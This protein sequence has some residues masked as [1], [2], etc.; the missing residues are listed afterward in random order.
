MKK[1]FLMTAIAVAF[2]NPAIAHD[3]KIKGKT[4]QTKESKIVATEFMKAVKSLR[5]QGIKTGTFNVTMDARGV[6]LNPEN[7]CTIITPDDITMECP[8]SE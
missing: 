8:C 4:T 3:V 5:A 2:S 6:D 1:F 7:C